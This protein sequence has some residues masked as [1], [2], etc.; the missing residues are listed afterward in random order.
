MCDAVANAFVT[1]KRPDKAMEE[2]EPVVQ[3]K[4]AVP[5]SPAS[6][7]PLHQ[8]QDLFREAVERLALLVWHD[9]ILGRPVNV[10]TVGSGTTL[11]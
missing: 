4:E 6:V 8:I 10:V 5:M 2:K 11:S 7:T 9:S 3:E 1:D